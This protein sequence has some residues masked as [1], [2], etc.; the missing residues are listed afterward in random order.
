M[1][2]DI[3]MGDSQIGEFGRGFLHPVFA[4]DQLPGGERR[5]DRGG[6]LGF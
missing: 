6:G 2:I 1:Q 3:G 5:D 4:E